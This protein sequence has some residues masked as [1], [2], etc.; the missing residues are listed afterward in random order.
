M[1]SLLD[2]LASVGRDWEL[3]HGLEPGG[4]V[5]FA[6]SLRTAT[7]APYWDINGRKVT[8][9]AT[10]GEAPAPDLV[11]LPDFHIDPVAELPDDLQA[12]AE[13]VASAHARGALVASVCSGS[14]VLGASGLLDGKDATTH[15]AM[16]DALAARNKTVRVRRERVLVPVGEGHRIITAGGASAWSDLILYLIARFSGAETARRVAKVWLLNTHDDGQLSYASLAAGRQHEDRLVGDAQAWAAD[17]YMEPSPVAEMAARS[18]LSER[19]FLRRFRRATGQSPAEYVQTLRV[20]EAKQMLETTDA[21]IDDIAGDVGYAEP[22]S[23][24]TAFRR[25]VGMTASVYRRKWRALS[26]VPA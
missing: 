18:G 10:L 15:W 2:V 3:L 5:T 14:M 25:N 24:R 11:I 16:A 7:G 9:D 6:P 17:H 19:G 23:F 1:F 20:E 12:A 22:S 8:P 26:P 21:A 13:W 4:C